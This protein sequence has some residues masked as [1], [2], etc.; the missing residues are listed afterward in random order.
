MLNE[1]EASSLTSFF[2]GYVATRLFEGRNVDRQ[3]DTHEESRGSLRQMFSVGRQ[4][5]GRAILFNML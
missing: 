5:A 4:V 2:E 1:V 3:A